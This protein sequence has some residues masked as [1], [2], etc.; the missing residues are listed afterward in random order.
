MSDV[1]ASIRRR[2]AVQAIA[3]KIATRAPSQSVSNQ[4]SLYFRDASQGPSQRSSAIQ[5][6]K[7]ADIGANRPVNR[8][9]SRQAGRAVPAPPKAAQRKPMTNRQAKP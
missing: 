8:S 7:T 3:A 2:I 5:A 9:R 1:P 4:F 6:T